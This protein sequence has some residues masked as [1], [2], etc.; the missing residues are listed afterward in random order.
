M[1]DKFRPELG[2]FCFGQPWKEYE[3]QEDVEDALKALRSLLNALAASPDYD[4]PFNNTGAGFKNDTFE[5]QAYNWNEESDQ[6]FN[7]KWKDFEVSWYKY[8]GRGSS[9]NRPMDR[10]NSSKCSKNV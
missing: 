10:K 1:N 8:L 9:Q 3:L 4:N 2:Q 7:F 6:K 5:V